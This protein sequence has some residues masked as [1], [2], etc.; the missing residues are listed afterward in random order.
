MSGLGRPDQASKLPRRPTSEADRNVERV[1]RVKPRQ[2]RARSGR[3]PPAAIGAS[4]P[5]DRTEA[6]SESPASST[7]IL[8]HSRYPRPDQTVV[9]V[10]AS[11]L[12]RLQSD[13]ARLR[14]LESS[15]DV[16][17]RAAETRAQL[18]RGEVDHIV[19]QA[20]ERITAA[21]NR[22]ASVTAKGVLPREIAAH[23]LVN[24]SAGD[25]LL[26]L[27]ECHVQADPV[28]SGYNVHSRDGRPV[29]DFIDTTLQQPTFSHF[30]ARTAPANPVQPNRP[31]APTMFPTP[32]TDRPESMGENWVRVLGGMR[33]KHDQDRA[34]R[35][36]AVEI[37]VP[38]GLRRR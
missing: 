7:T 3:L 5:S 26:S 2:K 4:D 25:Q 14:A 15:R 6:S 10:P 22:A 33:A 21:E 31:D 16:E 23:P 19:R 35:N 12:S 24:A 9:S 27:L 29:A 37:G 11:E 32:P 20:Q 17:L 34:V 28:G 36:A 8:F 30:L 13:A 38:F 1:A 18:T